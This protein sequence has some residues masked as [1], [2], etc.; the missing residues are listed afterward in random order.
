M[1]GNH[2]FVPAG[3]YGEAMHGGFYV[4]YD[5]TNEQFER[6]L[7]LRVF[8]EDDERVNMN[9][10]A[11]SIAIS[12]QKPLNIFVIHTGKSRHLVQK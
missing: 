2:G 4:L 8:D 11:T 9:R 5:E 7:G 6:E 1:A 10:C 12:I 3:N